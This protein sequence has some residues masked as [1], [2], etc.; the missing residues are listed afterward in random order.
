MADLTATGGHV[1]LL[2]RARLSAGIA[3]AAPWGI[4]LDG[5]LAAQT[6]AQRKDDLR[7]AGT[8][9]A[10]LAGTPDPEDLAL[11]LARC[12]AGGG[13]WHWAATCAFPEGRA[14]V[15]PEVRYW[16]GRIDERA[17]G[18]MAS[19]LPA[20]LSARQG[21]YRSR[22]MPLLVTVCQA[23]T[24]HA[25]GDRAAI[26]AALDGLMAIGKKRS[27]GEGHV[28]SWQVEPADLGEW[29]AGH[30]HPDG[31]LGRPVPPQCLAGYP[32]VA[33]GPLATA[34]LRPPYMHPARQRE[35]LLPVLAD[36]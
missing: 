33:R 9:P 28:L 22:R 3:W 7:A 32:A 13:L 36:D 4:A 23:V 11:P 21:R 18:Q 20:V 17:A 27:A 19:A 24:W 1:P 26:A 29:Q 10:G 16:T 25:V 5:L 31:T 2:I 12:T 34:G 15:L 14:S 6:W 30:L 35:L 8:P